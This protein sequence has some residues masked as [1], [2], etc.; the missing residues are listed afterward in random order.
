MIEARSLTKKYGDKV[1]VDDLSFTVKPG[2]VTGFL[3]PNGAGKSTTMRMILGLDRPTKGA[4]LINGKPYSHANSPM[5]EVGALLDAKDVHGGRTA[6]AHLKALA[7]SNGLPMRRVD[8]VL[9]LTG[10]TEVAGKRIKGFSLGMSQRL[11]IA[12][13]MLGDP[14]ILMFDE[15]VN[16][17]D[18]EGILWIRNFMQSLAAAAA[19]PSSSPV[20]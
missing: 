11:G 3:G 13:A 6:R 10:M 8:E 4:A 5:R 14:Q 17:L 2:T 7:Q 12:A 20:T 9:E 15:P 16:G 18:P 19:G 1:A